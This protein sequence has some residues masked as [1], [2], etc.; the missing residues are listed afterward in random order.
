M[1]SG[2]EWGQK[3]KK[4]RYS[5]KKKMKALFLDAHCLRGE[6]GRR[7]YSK[8]REGRYLTLKAGQS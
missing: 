2:V 8:P 4:C 7:Q 5:A 1:F 6:K 3:G